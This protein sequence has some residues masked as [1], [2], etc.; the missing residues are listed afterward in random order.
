MQFP[1]EALDNGAIMVRR[2]LRRGVPPKCEPLRISHT[3]NPLV[4]ACSQ[5]A[6]E[7]AQENVIWIFLFLS[8]LVLLAVSFAP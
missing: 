6:A 7:A 3:S 1:F 5:A 8:T 2:R 4:V